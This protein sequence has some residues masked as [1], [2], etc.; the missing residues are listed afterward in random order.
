MS[1]NM[2]FKNCKKQKYYSKHRIVSW[3]ILGKL[4]IKGNIKNQTV[5][6]FA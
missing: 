6:I 2:R 1:V 3:K 5:I 4:R